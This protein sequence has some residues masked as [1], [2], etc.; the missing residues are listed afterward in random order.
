MRNILVF[1]CLILLYSCATDY[2]PNVINN[3]PTGFIIS[4]NRIIQQIEVFD[5][6]K[7]NFIF[8][9]G[10]GSPML[11]S[12]TFSHVILTDNSIHTSICSRFSVRKTI[13]IQVIKSPLNIR[14]DNHNCKFKEYK[15]GNW[16]DIFDLGKDITGVYSIPPRDTSV[17]VIDFENNCLIKN[18]GNI[19]SAGYISFNL[20]WDKMFSDEL[21]MVSMP[22]RYCTEKGSLES[23][24]DY[25]I[26]T[27][28]PFDIIL[29]SS[30]DA[31]E[32]LDKS[33]NGFIFRMGSCLWKNY[34]TNSISLGDKIRLDSVVVKHQ[35]NQNIIGADIIGLNFLKR[36]NIILNL[37]KMVMLIK[38]IKHKP[39]V[40]KGDLPPFFK[41]NCRIKL[42]KDSLVEI[43]SVYEGSPF[44]RLGVKK[45]D[46]V[47]EINGVY[48]HKAFRTRAF[49]ANELRHKKKLKVVL[50][51]DSKE[52]TLTLKE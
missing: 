44:Y 40:A 47:K 27:G 36:F 38:P 35:I 24:K 26:D 4:D 7:T 41:P 34:S 17:W 23:L 42:T 1:V 46:V 48:S 11:D 15:I 37:R 22:V 21:L 52:L 28:N 12:S 30:F 31:I 18:P 19:D 29:S 20:K 25:V 51:R 16:E 45:G 49:V 3:E 5:S 33:E 43:T 8:D 2:S 50:F 6:I 13:N 39:I 14:A 10:F 32:F 9:T